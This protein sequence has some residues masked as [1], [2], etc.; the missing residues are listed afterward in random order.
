VREFYQDDSAQWVLTEARLLRFDLAGKQLASCIRPGHASLD[1][2]MYVMAPDGNSGVW[3]GSDDGVWSLQNDRWTHLLTTD[4]PVADV[5]VDGN[6]ELW[7][8]VYDRKWT[9]QNRSS[10]RSTRPGRP[11]G[12][13]GPMPPVYAILYHYVGDGAWESW[14][15]LT[16]N[17]NV[18]APVLMR[19]HCDLWDWVSPP[20]A[21]ED[22]L[23]P[24]PPLADIQR[25]L[26]ESDLPL[27]PPSALQR[28]YSA[29]ITDPQGAVWASRHGSDRLLVFER[30]HWSEIGIE[31]ESQELSR[32]FGFNTLCLD[33]AGNVWIGSGN[34]VCHLDRPVTGAK[35][36]AVAGL[37]EDWERRIWAGLVY[38]GVARLDGDA[39]T[40][41]DADS[42]ALP[43]DL[44]TSLAVDTVRQRLYA[45]THGGLAMFDGQ[46]WIDLGNPLAGEPMWINA[47]ALDG[48]DGSVW[49]GYYSG[50]TREGQ[51]AGSLLRYSSDGWDHVPF[52][53][54]AA[55]GALLVDGAG[56]LWAGLIPI[57]FSGHGSFDPQAGP[58][59][60]PPIW[61]YANGE[62]HPVGTAQGLGIPAVF[63]LAET[64]DGTIWAAGA[65]GISTIDPAS[66]WGEP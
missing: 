34:G 27:L 24:P 46:S 6:G 59:D 31:T 38:R 61:S 35:L 11:P 5:A 23:H 18:P 21:C 17:T 13:A 50:P 1:W 29:V 47:L 32:W 54:Q 10:G 60:T 22:K 40:R 14:G 8:S 55:V 15:G 3:V 7:A 41:F 26:E 65:I 58:S 33:S 30:G 9:Y 16:G 25:W 44:V 66:I 45:G 19:D 56:R 43:S 62:W 52:P 63:A 42:G 4:Q 57:G 64:R 37:V 36:G 51:F 39:W 48:D 53:A 28:I 12:H 20:S 49:V 2:G